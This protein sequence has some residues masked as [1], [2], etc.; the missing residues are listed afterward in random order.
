MPQTLLTRPVLPQSSPAAIGEL[1]IDPTTHEFVW[2][3]GTKVYSPASSAIEQINAAPVFYPAP[4]GQGYAGTWNNV[5]A[6]GGGGSTGSTQFPGQPARALTYASA[7]SGLYSFAIETPSTATNL[8]IQV[9]LTTSLSTGATGKYK[10]NVGVARLLGTY[11]AG[12]TTF[13]QPVRASYTFNTA[14]NPTI[15]ADFNTIATLSFG[16]NA[17]TSGTTRA[18][19]ALQFDMPDTTNWTYIGGNIVLCGIRVTAS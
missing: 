11:P 19:I 12:D 14:K 3:N 9:E 17:I 6:G 7:I 13:T 1:G 2:H 18:L 15:P 8:A 5:I 16:T 4:L 10:C